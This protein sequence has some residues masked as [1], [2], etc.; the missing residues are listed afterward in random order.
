[1]IFLI[2]L[3]I[4]IILYYTKNGFK[5]VIERKVTNKL[6]DTNDYSKYFSEYLMIKE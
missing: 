6:L 2:L 4:Y 5:N 3:L 1:M